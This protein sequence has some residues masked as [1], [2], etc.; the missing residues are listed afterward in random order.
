MSG[1]HGTHFLKPRQFPRSLAR[2]FFCFCWFSVICCRCQW[3]PSPALAVVSE[4]WWASQVWLRP[5]LNPGF[6]TVP[7]ISPAC[8]DPHGLFDWII[9][10]TIA[11]C[12]RMLNGSLST[13]S[14][15]PPWEAFVAFCSAGMKLSS[16]DKKALAYFSFPCLWSAS[17]YLASL[18]ESRDI[19]QW[20]TCWQI[21]F[22]LF[23]RRSCRYMSSLYSHPD[24][25]NKGPKEV[26]QE[27]KSRINSNPL[28]L[29]LPKHI[30]NYIQ[31]L[32]TKKATGQPVTFTDIFGMLIGETLIPSVRVDPVL[33]QAGLPFPFIDRRMFPF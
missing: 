31:A 2:I 26:N 3:S 19:F 17:S 28:R 14:L 29:L 8:R 18:T 27:L 33:L 16:R 15:S 12:S 10:L 7:R 30:S 23:F 5:C 6:W 24:F 13:L 11:H 4:P 25:P 32:W 9:P 22:C 1:C 21:A 20:L